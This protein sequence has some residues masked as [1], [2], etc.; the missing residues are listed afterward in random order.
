MSSKRAERSGPHAKRSLGR[1]VVVGGSITG[2]L[3][4]R[5][6][7]DHFAEVIVLE[8]DVFPEGAAARR[9][10]PQA[11]HVHSLLSRGRALFEQLF[12]GLLQD[13]TAHGA[14]HY[15]FGAHMHVEILGSRLPR[16]R[17]GL[18]SVSCSR[19]LLE[20]R[21]RQKLLA[22]SAVEVREGARVLRLH[23]RTQRARGRVDGVVV[24]FSHDPEGAAEQVLEADLV[25]DASGRGSQAPRWLAGSASGCERMNRAAGVS[26]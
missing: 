19:A 26:R 21:V 6:L 22:S 9:G 25:V 7:S 10:V 18:Q 20:W 16:F 24:R 14:I 15:D 23:Q 17:S 2:L 13:L 12:P 11:S 5:V 4:A 8:Q 1:A 3:T